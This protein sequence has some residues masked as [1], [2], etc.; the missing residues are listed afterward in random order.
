MSSSLRNEQRREIIDRLAT[1]Q[2]I[3][4]EA[5]IA[6][7]HLLAVATELKHIAEALPKHVVSPNDTVF[8]ITNTVNPL[9]TQGRMHGS[10]FF[11]SH[12]SA[13]YEAG[14][15]IKAVF[16]E[17]FRATHNELLGVVNKTITDFKLDELQQL[18]V[19]ARS[20]RVGMPLAETPTV[21]QAARRFNEVERWVI[22]S[23]AGQCGIRLESADHLDQLYT[24][25]VKGFGVSFQRHAFKLILFNAFL[26]SIS[27]HDIKRGTFLFSVS[28]YRRT[29]IIDF[30]AALRVLYIQED[31]VAELEGDA[32]GRVYLN[33]R[34][35]R[36]IKELDEEKTRIDFF[37][38]LYEETCS[39]LPYLTGHSDIEFL[40]RNQNQSGRPKFHLLVGTDRD[41]ALFVK[42]F[43]NLDCSQRAFLVPNKRPHE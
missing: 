13:L 25:E 36:R 5:G 16:V 2:G 14:K 11:A 15:L 23:L 1:V 39:I 26:A 29:P 35:R 30:E 24:Q 34:Q 31:D 6:E 43:S 17:T 32:W 3:I 9:P 18:A 12:R 33:V 21:L 8:L 10:E 42:L 4:E 38:R 27:E 7:G 28:R 19:Q 41:H 37:F 20:S 40:R 22:E